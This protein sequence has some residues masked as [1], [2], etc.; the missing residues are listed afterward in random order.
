MVPPARIGAQRGDWRAGA[1]NVEVSGMTQWR[2]ATDEP[3]RVVRYTCPKCRRWLE[4]VA[5]RR[6]TCVLCRVRMKAEKRGRG[7]DDGEN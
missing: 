4:E 6:M 1:H 7:D 5:G 3:A 2:P